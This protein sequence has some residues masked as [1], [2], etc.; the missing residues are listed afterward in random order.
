MYR[1]FIEQ[2][3]GYR[4]DSPPLTTTNTSFLAQAPSQPAETFRTSLP[5]PKTVYTILHH[6]QLRPNNLLVPGITKTRCLDEAYG[7]LLEANQ[8]AREYVIR[9]VLVADEPERVLQSERAEAEWL[10]GFVIPNGEEENRDSEDFPYSVCIAVFGPNVEEIT[11]EVKPLDFALPRRRFLQD[12]A[13]VPSVGFSDHGNAGATGSF[14]ESGPSFMKRR[15]TDTA[16]DPFGY[17]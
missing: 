14:G 13:P 4:P 10:D 17:F 16:L 9:G 6:E 7:S 12:T 15:R 11:I 8:A 2:L 1:V 3:H 5:P